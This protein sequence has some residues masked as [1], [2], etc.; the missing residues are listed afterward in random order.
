MDR[1]GQD[2][3]QRRRRSL[4]TLDS[5]HGVTALA[6]RNGEVGVR[7]DGVQL[8]FVAGRTV[9]H[10]LRIGEFHR[11]RHVHVVHQ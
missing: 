11:V 6:G 1:F 9:R 5:R 7:Q 2:G 3:R 8:A 4:D 10:G